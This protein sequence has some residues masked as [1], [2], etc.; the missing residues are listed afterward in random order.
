MMPSP[1]LLVT[2]NLSTVSTVLSLPEC[3]MVF[4][5]DQVRLSDWLLSLGNVHWKFLRIFP[6]LE[7]L[8]L[9]SNL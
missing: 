2:T 3:H 4:L 7:S 9:F 5:E 1:Q 6:W 8:F